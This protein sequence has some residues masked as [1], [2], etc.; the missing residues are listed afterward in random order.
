MLHGVAPKTSVKISSSGAASRSRI[1]RACASTSSTG[2]VGKDVEGGELDGAIGIGVLGDR[3]ERRGERRVGDDEE[4][5]HGEV[6]G[7]GLRAGG[8]APKKVSAASGPPATSAFRTVAWYSLRPLT[9]KAAWATTRRP[10]GRW[11]TM[12][13]RR[14]SRV[15]R[16]AGRR[17]RAQLGRRSGQVGRGLGAKRIEHRRDAGGIGGV[18]RGEREDRATGSAGMELHRRRALRRCG[19]C[20]SCLTGRHGNIRATPLPSGR[21]SRQSNVG[22]HAHRGNGGQERR[23]GAPDARA[24]RACLHA[25]IIRGRRQSRWTA[26]RR[27]CITDR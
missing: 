22:E 13:T 19:V 9:K 5:G 18:D 12:A 23:G 10:S 24:A 7:C 15:R 8:S 14:T 6:G 21:A 20:R 27:A 2:D 16:R 17:E 4:T 1:W 26:G 3:L 25:P 11:P